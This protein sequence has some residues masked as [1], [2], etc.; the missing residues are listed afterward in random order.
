MKELPYVKLRNIVVSSREE[1][2]LF[3]RLYSDYDRELAL[4]SARLREKPVS[5]S[6][7]LDMYL[8]SFLMKL[9]LVNKAGAVVGFCLLGFGENTHPDTDYYIAE[10]YVVP[11]VR[12]K[13]YGMAAVKQLL[14]W[15]PGKHCYHVLKENQ[16]AL[17]FWKA[18]KEFCHWVDLPITDTLEL[19]DCFFYAFDTNRMGALYGHR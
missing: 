15:F 8:N 2:D 7:F 9:F 4:Y 17:A 12:Q 1:T 6:D 19:H 14:A 18:T 5:G 10:F 3:E 13:G 11:E 16:A